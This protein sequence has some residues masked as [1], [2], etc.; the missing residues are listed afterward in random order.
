MILAAFKWHSNEFDVCAQLRSSC[1]H[2]ASPRT[3]TDTSTM[4]AIGRASS[5]ALCSVN[6]DARRCL[7]VHGSLC[8][9]C[10][11]LGPWIVMILT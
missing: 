7:R 11:Y 10:V 1:S 4:L 9:T 5:S 2:A 3:H 6:A 8:R